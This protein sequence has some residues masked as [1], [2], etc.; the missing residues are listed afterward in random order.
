LVLINQHLIKNIHRKKVF[1]P[2]LAAV[3]GPLKSSAVQ[4]TLVVVTVTLITT[5]TGEIKTVT[6]HDRPRE[7]TIQTIK[8]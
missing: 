2:V 4:L 5:G 1:E 8:A 6:L 7:A 3:L